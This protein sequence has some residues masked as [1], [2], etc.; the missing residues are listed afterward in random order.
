[1]KGKWAR[2]LVE[3]EK[4]EWKRRKRKV[5]KSRVEEACAWWSRRVR[6]WMRRRRR[7][8]RVKVGKPVRGE[9]EWEEVGV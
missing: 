8:E 4:E 9:W 6:E 3:R 1:M 5:V 2:W 7:K